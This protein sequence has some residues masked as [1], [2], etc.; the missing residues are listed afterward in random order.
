MFDTLF[1]KNK[2]IIYTK[3]E[4]KTAIANKEPEIIVGGDLAK[5]LKWMTKLSVK[6]VGLLIGALGILGSSAVFTGGTSLVATSSFVATSGAVEGI[7]GKE[8]AEI[9]FCSGLSVAIILSVLKGY[10]VEI[11]ANKIKLTVK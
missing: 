1:N 10:N 2:K 6:K 5:K 11:E 4:L 7:V 9:I 3:D 8:I